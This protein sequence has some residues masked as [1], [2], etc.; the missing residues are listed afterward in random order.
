MDTFLME[1]GLINL[2]DD[3]NLLENY[4]FLYTRKK[5]GGHLTPRKVPMTQRLWKVLSQSF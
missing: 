5:R 4:V 2:W 1:D 3:V